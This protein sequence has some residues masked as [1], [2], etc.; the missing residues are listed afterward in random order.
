MLHSITLLQSV[1]RISKLLFEIIMQ[2]AT[3]S[4]CQ[5]YPGLV[6]GHTNLRYSE[7]EMAQCT[8]SSSVSAEKATLLVGHFCL[9]WRQ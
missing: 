3:T 8:M 2:R 5:T 1:N 4:R 9:Y 7:S 6:V